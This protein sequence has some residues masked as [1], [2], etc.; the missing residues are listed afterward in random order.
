MHCKHLDKNMHT[1][2]QVRR[3]LYYIYPNYLLVPDPFSLRTLT[4][5]AVAFLARPYVF[6]ITVPVKDKVFWVTI[7][8]YTS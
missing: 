2:S 1:W 6:D 4:A 5:I 8:Y 3:W 7:I